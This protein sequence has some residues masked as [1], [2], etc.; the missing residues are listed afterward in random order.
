MWLFD[1]SGKIQKY[2]T[3]EDIL[4]AFVPVRYQIYEQRKAFLVAKLERELAVIFNKLSFVEHVLADRLDVEKKKMLDLCRKMRKL[5]LKHM[6][7]IKGEGSVKHDSEQLGLVEPMQ[8]PEASRIASILRAQDAW[9]EPLNSIDLAHRLATQQRQLVD[10]KSD[11]F[12][13]MTPPS[14]RPPTSTLYPSSV[15]HEQ[16]FLQTTCLRCNSLWK[17]PVPMSATTLRLPSYNHSLLPTESEDDQD[18]KSPMSPTSPTNQQLGNET[19]KR[20]DDNQCACMEDLSTWHRPG[21]SNSE[22]WDDMP[23]MASRDRVFC[24]TRIS[25]IQV[26]PKTGMFQVRMVCQW[27]FRTFSPKNDTEV[28][29][30]GVPGIRVP[31]LEVDVLESRVWKDLESTKNNEQCTHCGSPNS[32]RNTIFWRGTSIFVLR[33]YK[34]YWVRDFPFDRHVI[35]LHQMDFVWRPTKDEA[36]QDPFDTMKVVWCP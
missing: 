3:P 13:L 15:R 36:N 23:S 27:A 24:H 10:Y 9:P 8:A 31:G 12:R 34:R 4:R 33:G 11:A 2:E 19:K 6:C 1:A 16:T 25:I 30:R 28:R 17:P 14:A 29:N 35:S 18:V 21:G 5:G 26:D 32:A 20:C 22:P 7:T